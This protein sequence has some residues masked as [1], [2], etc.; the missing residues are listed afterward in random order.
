[1]IKLLAILLFSV[2]TIGSVS[3]LKTYSKY[4]RKELKRQ[5]KK[6]DELAQALWKAV[7]YGLSL[8]VLLWALIGIFAAILFVLLADSLPSWLAIFGCAIVLW[9]SFAW[10]PNVRVSNASEKVARAVAPALASVMSKI[11][12]LLNKVAG[13]V[14]KHS[15]IHVHS[16]IYEKED[17]IELLEKQQDQ[18]DN[19]MTAAELSIVKH[20]L[21]FSD[22]LIRDV[23]TPKRVIKSV[24]ASDSM[25]PIL[26]AELHD[27]GFS[28]FPVVNGEE[29]EQ[30]VG[31]LYLRDLVSAKAS[32]S[33]DKL[34]SKHVYYVNEEKPLSHALQA[35]L[36]TKHHLF[37]VVNSFEEVV[38]LIT[39]EDVL[40]EV[41]GRQIVDEFDKYEDLRAVAALQAKKDAKTHKH[42][43][44][45][46]EAAP[47][48]A[49]PDTKPEPKS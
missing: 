15:R 44:P 1:M 20:A 46:E 48:S 21:S 10:L 12:P 40:E 19:R 43:K 34:M 35:F 14:H 2:L 6:G 45:A 5:A 4:S 41:L 38:G 7:S 42:V 11:Y 39:I 47:S 3:L 16:G 8:N 24:K 13:F 29:P 23:M 25:G 27:S 17:L 33:V 28:R 9:L 32:G 36:R 22:V 18:P 26:M 31:T 30:I 49:T 37:I